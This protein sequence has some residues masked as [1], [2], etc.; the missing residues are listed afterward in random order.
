MIEQ[1]LE[2]LLARAF[3]RAIVE[4]LQSLPF[5]LP[6]NPGAVLDAPKPTRRKKADE[7]KEVIPNADPAPAVETAPAV[8]L[9]EAAAPARV[10]TPVVAQ[11]AAE[12]ENRNRDA[13][14][15]LPTIERAHVS[16]ALITVAQSPE[17]GPQAAYGIL[18]KLGVKEVK[19][20]K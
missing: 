10:Q 3:K 14:A 7:P 13:I 1:A 20:L 8:A 4:A 15:E 2:D 19:D 12:V 9:A 6:A 11:A 17:H 18:G 5:T 16:A